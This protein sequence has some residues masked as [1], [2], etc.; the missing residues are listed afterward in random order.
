MGNRSCLTRVIIVAHRVHKWV[1]LM[2]P[3]H[4]HRPP[5]PPAQAY[6]VSSSL[7]LWKLASSVPTLFLSVLWLKCVVSSAIG[8]YLLDTLLIYYSLNC[9]ALS[10]WPGDIVNSQSCGTSVG[11]VFQWSEGV[12]PSRD[13]TTKIPCTVPRICISSQSESQ[14]LISSSFH[15]DK[16]L[17]WPISTLLRWRIG[18]D[19]LDW[20]LLW[21]QSL[22]GK[23][24][25]VWSSSL[26]SQRA[27]TPECLA[28][29]RLLC[30][31]SLKLVDSGSCY[32]R[33]PLVPWELPIQKPGL[34]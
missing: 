6:I 23:A 11:I 3:P 4:P 18:V 17:W 9:K 14:D 30:Y 10:L 8:P 28:S 34:L 33:A 24:G 5:S 32:S 31:G 16:W 2:I 29:S 15:T 20:Y 26:G 22:F 13:V 27:N 19:H 1:S 12:L 21:L 7:V 25:G